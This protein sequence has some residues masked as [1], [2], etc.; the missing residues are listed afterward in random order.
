MSAHVAIAESWSRNE[1]CKSPP[2]AA[3]NA[4]RRVG[5]PLSFGTTLAHQDSTARGHHGGRGSQL[6]RHE[7]RAGQVR[8]A[9]LQNRGC[10]M[11]A[12]CRCGHAFHHCSCRYIG[13]SLAISS[14]I[15][16]GTSF[17]ITK[18]GES[19]LHPAMS[20]VS[21]LTQIVHNHF[22]LDV[23]SFDRPHRCCKSKQ[24]QW[25]RQARASRS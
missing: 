1:E 8:E 2:R 3:L 13:L 7:P 17:I 18:K 16:I 19:T 4:P 10:R 11:K 14:S 23:P 21:R 5:A 12:D 24:Q 6:Q 25:L 20:A 22:L 15:A 9:L